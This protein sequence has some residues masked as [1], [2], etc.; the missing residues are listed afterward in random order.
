[1]QF[2]SLLLPVQGLWKEDKNKENLKLVSQQK[3]IQDKKFQI[4]SWEIAPQ[5]DSGSSNP[6]EIADDFGFNV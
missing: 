2:S 5:E 3:A 1:M 4:S 6:F